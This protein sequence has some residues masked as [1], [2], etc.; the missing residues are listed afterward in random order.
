MINEWSDMNFVVNPYRDT[1]TFI[2]ASI[3]DIQVLLDDHII[4]TQTMR[5]S[6]Y[7]KPF[8]REILAWERKLMLLQEILDDWL[9]VQATWMYLEPIFGSPDIQSQMPEEGRRFSAVDKIWKD[10]MRAVESD[11]Q[12]LAVVEI[13]KMSEKLKKCY[14]LLEQIQKGLND[15]LEKKRLYFPRFFFLSNDE[16]LEILSETKDPTRVQPHL[17]KCF[18]GIAKL[19]FTDILD[20]TVMKS[21]EGEE[22]VLDDVISTSKARG[23]VERWLLELEKAMKKSIR[24]QILLSLAAYTTTIRHKWVLEWPGQAVQSISTTYWTTDITKCFAETNP[25]EELK[26]Y[27]DVCQEQI[28]HIVDLVRGKLSLQNRFTLCAL[29]VLDVHGRD[30]LNDLIEKE[31]KKDN[32]FN[33]LSQVRIKEMN[34]MKI[35]KLRN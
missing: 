7:I 21:S 17:K 5:G 34:L 25:I 16:L 24:N 10:L 31:C 30:V 20:V 33:W 12:V 14:G 27:F 3:D 23:Q 11:T 22:V 26:K 9:K 8:E 19:T 1:G 32:D 13:D 2:L 15:Y 29:V 4:K 6:P 18:E 35:K 28:S